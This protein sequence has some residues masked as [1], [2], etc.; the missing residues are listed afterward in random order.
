M[1]LN[2]LKQNRS[3]DGYTKYF[4]HSSNITKTD[5][6]F[7]AFLPKEKVENCI[8]WLSGLT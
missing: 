1:S 2:L 6:K 3:F 7:S 5:M 4:E 8:V